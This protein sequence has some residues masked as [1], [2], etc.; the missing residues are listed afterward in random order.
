MHMHIP[1]TGIQEKA[2]AIHAWCVPRNPRRLAGAHRSDAVAL[3]DYGLF[4]LQSSRSNVND[5]HMVQHQQIVNS[6]LLRVDGLGQHQEKNAGMNSRTSAYFH[7]SAYYLL[8][9]RSS[10]SKN[11]A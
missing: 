10:P 6:G 3:E 8:C 9:P 2:A 1:E 7:Y 5:R 11:D 4:G